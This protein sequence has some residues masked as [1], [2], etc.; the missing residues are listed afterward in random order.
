M[1]KLKLQ[2]FGH[3]TWTADSLEKTGLLGK[4]EGRRRR[5]DGGWDGWMASLTQWTWAWANSGKWWRTGKPV[6][7]QSMGSKESDMTWWLNSNSADVSQHVPGWCPCGHS[8]NWLLGNRQFVILLFVR[9]RALLGAW[10]RRFLL[11]SVPCHFPSFLN[12]SVSGSTR[13]AFLIYHY[14]SGLN[15]LNVL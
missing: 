4:I 7:L 12:C 11:L 1:L 15:L 5:D 8:P 3:L 13:N 6:V 10:D 14:V 9:S 2:Y